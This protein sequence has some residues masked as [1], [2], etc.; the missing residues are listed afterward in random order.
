M[1]VK[2][3]WPSPKRAAYS[4][5]LLS[6]SGHAKSAIHRYRIAINEPLD[7]GLQSLS[8]DKYLEV[9]GF[10]PESRATLPY[11]YKGRVADDSARERPT[12]MHTSIRTSPSPFS[13]CW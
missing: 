10:R 8:S 12:R 2:S 7:Q 1:A 6:A 3:N 11:S 5:G 9:T 13:S 4:L